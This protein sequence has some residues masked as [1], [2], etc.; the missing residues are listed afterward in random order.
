MPG[1]DDRRG[2]PAR[3]SQRPKVAE[4]R[5]PTTKMSDWRRPRREW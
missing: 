1:V 4:R 5:R 3:G 2:T